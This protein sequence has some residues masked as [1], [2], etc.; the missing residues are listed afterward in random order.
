MACIFPYSWAGQFP[1]EV[2]TEVAKS[3]WL[4]GLHDLTEEQIE[5]GLHRC[6]RKG[7]ALPPSIGVFRG[8][9]FPTLEDLNLPDAEEAYYLAVMYGNTRKCDIEIIK[10]AYHKIGSGDF[11][12]LPYKE[13]KP[14]FM[15]LYKKLAQDIIENQ[16]KKLEG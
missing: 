4:E 15:K 6:R 11:S 9:C 5:R 7:R 12:H 13:V 16:Y 10:M 3:E 14:R 8:W 2:A 1:H